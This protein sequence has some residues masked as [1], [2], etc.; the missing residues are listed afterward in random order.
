LSRPGRPFGIA[1]VVVMEA[2][3][4]FSTLAGGVVLLA[5][6]QPPGSIPPGTP[7]E[8]VAIAG[9]VAVAIG[10]IGLFLTWGVWRGQGWAWTGTF[11]YA[12]IHILVSIVYLPLSFPQ[13]F[14]QILIDA[15][16]VYCLFKPDVRAYCKRGP[17]VGV[18]IGW[19]PTEPP[20]REYPRGLQPPRLRCRHCGALN[21]PEAVYCQECGTPLR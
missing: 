9:G 5:G 12:L 20:S 13:T 17:P 6:L 2:F 10:A 4:G 11:V 3:I 15:L 8:A 1:L 7:R 16:I 14:P 21:L 19:E 18:P